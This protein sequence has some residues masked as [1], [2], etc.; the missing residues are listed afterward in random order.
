MLDSTDFEAY[1]LEQKKYEE[2]IPYESLLLD[3]VKYKTYESKLNEIY[4]DAK[5]A[6]GR[7]SD[8]NRKICK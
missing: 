8:E 6:D 3:N 1:I 2:N 4:S 5:R 7:T